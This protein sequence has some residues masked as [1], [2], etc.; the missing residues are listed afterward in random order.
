MHLPDT[1]LLTAEQERS[2]AAT[3]EVGLLAAEM[4]YGHRRLATDATDA[5]LAALIRRGRQAEDMFLTANLRLVRMITS[6]I[7]AHSA[8]PHEDLFQEG[9]LGLTEAIRRFDH[10]RGVRFSSYAY[11]WIRARVLASLADHATIRRVRSGTDV[12]RPDPVMLPLVEAVLPGCVDHGFAERERQ[13]VPWSEV[14][15]DLSQ[16]QRSALELRYGFD[17]HA[18]RNYTE[19]ATLMAVSPATVRRLEERALALVRRRLQRRGIHDPHAVRLS[20]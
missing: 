9:C 4:R 20:T 17:G 1:R 16:A 18:P 5:E 12:D 15:D 7:A 3:V 2:L 14:A 13:V 11:R 6:R 10:R 19:T 8:V